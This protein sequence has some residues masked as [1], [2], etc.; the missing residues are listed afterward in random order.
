M[1]ENRLF[2]CA[3]GLVLP[4]EPA[5]YTTEAAGTVAQPS[6]STTFTPVSVIKTQETEDGLCHSR[7]LKRIP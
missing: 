4:I 2:V 1:E 5:E 6:R 7:F 3:G